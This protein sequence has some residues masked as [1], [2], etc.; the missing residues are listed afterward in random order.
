MNTDLVKQIARNLASTLPP[1]VVD[2]DD[3]VQVG[4]I[5]YLD[6]QSRFSSEGNP[7]VPF[8]AY[9]STRIRGAMIDELRNADWMSREY[10][11]QYKTVTQATQQ[12]F[13]TLGRKPADSEVA[14]A[15]D[16]PL[17]RYREVC[18]NINLVVIS[19]EDLKVQDTDSEAFLDHFFIDDNADPF[20]IMMDKERN[21]AV[22]KAFNDLPR[23]DRSILQMSYI[24]GVTL[25]DIG[26][27]F[28]VT[29]ARAHQMR[30]AALDK[31][32]LTLEEFTL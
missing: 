14:N 28:G 12:L 17:S 8:E 25:K 18:L 11:K 13:H 26:I 7:G 29:E 27:H 30:K 24:E 16:V 23:K 31:I 6:A 9:A 10:R 4:S 20:K 5:G 1:N 32:R 21:D 15:I 3:L 19:L 22:V 2:V